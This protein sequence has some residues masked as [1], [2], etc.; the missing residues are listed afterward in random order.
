MSFD[1][2][3]DRQDMQLNSLCLLV[4]M[5]DI[6]RIVENL[7]MNQLARF[8]I[9]IASKYVVSYICPSLLPITGKS[10]TIDSELFD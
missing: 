8:D 7:F 9:T 2:S 6:T 5:H 10:C 3:T 4:C 1:N